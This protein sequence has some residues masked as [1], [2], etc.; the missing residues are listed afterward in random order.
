[1]NKNECYSKRRMVIDGELSSET[2]I[3]LQEVN[4]E[5]LLLQKVY[6]L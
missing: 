1:M 6:L 4:S 3:Q 2:Q 5:P